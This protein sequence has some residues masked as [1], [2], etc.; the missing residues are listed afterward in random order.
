M[1]CLFF[2]NKFRKDGFHRVGRNT[3]N[4][5]TENESDKSQKE[6]KSSARKAT[7]SP[8]KMTYC[9]SAI[10]LFCLHKN[11]K[12]FIWRSDTSFWFASKAKL[13]LNLSFW[14]ESDI[15]ESAFMVKGEGVPAILMII[16]IMTL[17]IRSQN[18][19]KWLF[20]D[21]VCGGRT[22]KKDD[23]TKGGEYPKKSNRKDLSATGKL[24]KFFHVCAARFDVWKAGWAGVVGED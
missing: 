1:A 10:C 23:C 19:E 7:G 18:V 16:K 14:F 24:D 12:F 13:F 2:L 22:T 9:T 8:G 3:R 11:W 15:F 6:S 5:F 4:G 21:P 20:A 17:L